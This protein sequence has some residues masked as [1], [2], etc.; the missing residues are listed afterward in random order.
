MQKYGLEGAIFPNPHSDLL[1]EVQSLRGMTLS[2]SMDDL[3]HV[4]TDLL[5]EVQSLRDMTL[6]DSMQ[7]FVYVMTDVLPEVQ[8]LWKSGVAAKNFNRDDWDFIEFNLDKRV[9]FYLKGDEVVMNLESPENLSVVDH[10]E[11][12]KFIQKAIDCEAR[13]GSEANFK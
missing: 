1:P 4:T 9:T 12:T 13:S 5:P 3:T 11:A 8:Y 6:S 2:D 7:D 10:R